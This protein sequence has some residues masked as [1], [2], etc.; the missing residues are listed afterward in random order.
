MSHH[1]SPFWHHIICCIMRYFTTF[2]QNTVNMMP[3]PQLDTVNALLECCKTKQ[4]LLWHE[5]IWE[6]TDVCVKLYRCATALYLLS[7]LVHDWLWCWIISTWQRGCCWFKLYCQEVYLNVNYNYATEWSRSLWIT[8]GNT[9][10]KWKHR[11]QFNKGI[12]KTYFITNMGTWIFWS[13]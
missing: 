3:Q 5:Y 6:N 13:L 12:S 4:F 1:T 8:N 7:I 2:C 11:N 10:L 9:H